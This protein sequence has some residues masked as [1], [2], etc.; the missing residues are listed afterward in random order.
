MRLEHGGVELS[1]RVALIVTNN[2][3]YP[4][5]PP[6]S[7]DHLH[8]F[9]VEAFSGDQ[10]SARHGWRFLATFRGRSFV[11]IPILYDVSF[12]VMPQ[13]AREFI[14]D[15]PGREGG[16]ER[17][18]CSHFECVYVYVEHDWNG[19][20]KGGWNE[21]GSSEINSVFRFFFFFFLNFNAK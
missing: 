6:S 12:D 20:A 8:A 4:L 15:L 19:D 11:F 17:E 13:F 16:L 3:F 2:L 5:L 9:F 21:L 1:A 7:T 18:A 14:T 10:T